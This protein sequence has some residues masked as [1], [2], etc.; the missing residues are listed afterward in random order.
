MGTTNILLMRMNVTVLKRNCSVLAYFSVQ[1]VCSDKSA[2]CTLNA[3]NKRNYLSELCNTYAAK[4][5][6]KPLRTSKEK[7]KMIKILNAFYDSNQ[8]YPLAPFYY[9]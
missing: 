1:F 9:N 3:V 6:K 7:L 4:N 2:A 5:L 8:A